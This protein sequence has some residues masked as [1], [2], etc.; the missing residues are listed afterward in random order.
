[1]NRPPPE[2]A[3]KIALVTGASSGIGRAAAIELA[4]AGA[5]VVVHARR[6]AAAAQE[7]ADLIES[8]GGQAWVA[9]ADLSEV[10]EQDSLARD[11][12]SRHGAIDILVNNAGADVLTGEA[13]SWSFEKKLD[14]LWRVDVTASM[15]LTRAVGGLMRQRGGGAIINVGWDQAARGMAGDSGEIFAAIKGAV[16][17]FTRSAAH[18]L[19]PSVRV[20]CVA[21]GWIKTAWGKG[22]SAEWQRRAVAESL[23]ER[24]GEPADVAGAIRYLASPAASFITAQVIDVNGG[25]RRG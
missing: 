6:N 21:P 9:L 18:S 4:R 11:T 15:R 22:A 1:M 3:G 12:W 25:M 24:W 10:S 14:L 7:T 20:N 19:A 23:L 2:L 8:A 13:A 16:T 5:A 17:A